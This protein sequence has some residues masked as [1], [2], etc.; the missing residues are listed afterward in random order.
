MSKRARLDLWA[1]HQA[2]HL[3]IQGI[4]TRKED[5]IKAAQLFGSS[6]GICGRIRRATRIRDEALKSLDFQST[7]QLN[8]FLDGMT[9]GRNAGIKEMKEQGYNGRDFRRVGWLLKSYDRD[10][11]LHELGI[12]KYS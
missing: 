5:P 4:M 10:A 2:D 7:E 12:K 11:I 6:V 8:A 9:N 3:L 1:S